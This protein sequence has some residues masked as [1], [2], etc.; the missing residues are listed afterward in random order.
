MTLVEE[1]KRTTIQTW[2]PP[3]YVS[4]LRT[5]RLI[6][7]EALPVLFAEASELKLDLDCELGG[8]VLKSTFDLGHVLEDPAIS[9]ILRATLPLV[10]LLKLFIA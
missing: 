2:R 10:R 8:E 5:S 7:Q 9:L 3:K 4:F 6:Y 1:G